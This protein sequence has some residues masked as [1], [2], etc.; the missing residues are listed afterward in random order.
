MAEDEMMGWH[1]QHNVHEFEQTL[2]D[3]EGQGSLL[4]CSPW[5]HKDLDSTE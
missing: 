5:G 4:C 1:H 3:S 2:G